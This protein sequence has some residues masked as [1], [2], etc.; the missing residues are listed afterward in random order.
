[1]EVDVDSLDPEFDEIR[2]AFFWSWPAMLEE[3]ALLDSVDED[4]LHRRYEKMLDLFEALAMG[5][6]E[7]DVA[8]EVRRYQRLVELRRPEWKPPW[9]AFLP[10]EE[11]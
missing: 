5:N 4:D 8:V 1:M 2:R 9:S 7:R 11:I 3:I 10:A 6:T